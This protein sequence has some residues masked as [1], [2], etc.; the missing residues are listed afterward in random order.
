MVNS[1]TMHIWNLVG[2]CQRPICFCA[3]ETLTCVPGMNGTGQS[4]WSKEPQK[5][6]TTSDF[7]SD[8]DVRMTIRFLP[9]LRKALQM[10]FIR[11]NARSETHVACLTNSQIHS[12]GVDLE[13]IGGLRIWSAR[14][15]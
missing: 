8:H 4:C 11:T 5:V 13:I 6:F 2:R 14:F 9:G 3:T 7:I 12:R 1:R 10:P 15:E